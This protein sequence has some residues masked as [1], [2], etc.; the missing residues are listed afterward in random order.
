MVPA[1]G[2]GVELIGGSLGALAALIEAP[3]LD[4]RV[5][6]SDAAGVLHADGQGVK[7]GVVGD[8]ELSVLISSPAVDGAVALSEGA[9]MS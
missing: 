4:L 5:A 8:V 9:A 2:D 3:A 1:G 7:G 6:A